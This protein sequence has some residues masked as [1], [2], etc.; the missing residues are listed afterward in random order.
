MFSLCQEL[1]GHGFA[2]GK[3]LHSCAEK[4]ELAEAPCHKNY[5]VEGCPVA[6]LSHEGLMYYKVLMY[7]KRQ[8]G[9]GDKEAG[10]K[11]Q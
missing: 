3:L 9:E 2:F 1:L 6:L 5:P 11:S 7:H 10:F 4:T 8:K